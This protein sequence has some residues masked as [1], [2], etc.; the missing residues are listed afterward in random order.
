MTEK[1]CISSS[2]RLGGA[3]FER[4]Q[5]GTLHTRATF[6]QGRHAAECHP[7]L[8]ELVALSGKADSHGGLGE[9]TPPLC[10][11]LEA[12]LARCTGARNANS[13]DQLAGGYH[14]LA[15]P[16]IKGG[17]RYCSMA[18]RAKDFY[19]RVQSIQNR[20]G[21]NDARC[22]S[23]ARAL[24]RMMSAVARDRVARAGH[25]A[26]LAAVERRTEEPAAF[27]LAEITDQGR[28][29]PNL[30]GGDERNAFAQGRVTG[31][32]PF[33]LDALSQAGAGTCAGLVRL[34]VV[35]RA[36]KGAFAEGGTARRKSPQPTA[37]TVRRTSLSMPTTASAG[38]DRLVQIPLSQNPS[39][40]LVPRANNP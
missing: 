13:H 17:H 11:F 40:P 18:L 38:A 29:V 20:S 14:R 24:D 31:A 21:V 32:K 9:V 6:R 34:D 36:V 4:S 7:C 23:A 28:D 2:S 3:T 25:A 22:G 33:V 8:A 26:E 1:E 39:V 27:F 19:A 30:S 37:S 15:R 35:A 10:V 12:L 16:G 5:Q